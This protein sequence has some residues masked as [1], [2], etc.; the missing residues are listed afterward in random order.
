MFCNFYLVKNHKIENNSMTTKAGEKISTYSESLEFYKLFGIHF[1][2]FKCNQFLLNK[3]SH[4]FLMQPSYLLG[5]GASILYLLIT[6][7][8]KVTLTKITFLLNSDSNIE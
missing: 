7:S 2:K 5:E 6:F 3:S 1:P 8:L 4:R